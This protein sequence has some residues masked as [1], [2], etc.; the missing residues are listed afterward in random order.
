MTVDLEKRLEALLAE[1]T[2]GPWTQ[3]VE[4]ERYPECDDA[5]LPAL[6]RAPGGAV[7][8]YLAERFGAHLE[9]LNEADAALIVEAKNALP[10]LL[11][12]LREYR[13]ALEARPAMLEREAL[14]PEVLAFAQLMERQLRANDHKPGWKNDLA[15]DLLP[16]LREETDEL[17][18]ATNR[19]A[20]QLG[21]GDAALYLESSR[22]NV[23]REAADVGNFAMMIADVS[24]VLPTTGDVRGAAP[25]REMDLCSH[26][27]GCGWQYPA[28]AIDKCETCG[29]SGVVPSPASPPSAHDMREDVARFSEPFDG[30]LSGIVI[31]HQLRASA[32]I[33]DQATKRQTG[34]ADTSDRAG[35]MREAASVIEALASSPM[36]AV[37]AAV[38]AERAACAKV[39]D[40]EIT[41]IVNQTTDGRGSNVAR[42][43]RDMIRARAG[44]GE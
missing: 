39:A 30:M 15:M 2:P 29:G 28:Q 9:R 21:W 26:C 11:T 42:R 34:W 38:E 44:G 32:A 12:Q 37:K 43:I 23:A 10:A 1:A 40:D 14:R 36:D 7:I 13:T 6:I 33:Q 8:A 17:E 19:L 35:L 18:E 41:R 5:D 31:V 4:P 22:N 20:K 24:G 16:R 25:E 3:K 27:N